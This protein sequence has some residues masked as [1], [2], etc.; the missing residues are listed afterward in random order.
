VVYEFEMWT[1]RAKTDVLMFCTESLFPDI[2][3]G[4]RG[5]SV[6]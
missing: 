1:L 2:R 5:Q 6:E 4:G 3:G